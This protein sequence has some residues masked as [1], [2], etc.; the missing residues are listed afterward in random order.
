MLQG[1]VLASTWGAD[2]PAH[3]QEALVAWV[4]LVGLEDLL[5]LPYPPRSIRQLS[6][7]ALHRQFKAGDVCQLDNR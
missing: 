4:G 3:Q 1:A 7:K 6:S 2:M 5:N